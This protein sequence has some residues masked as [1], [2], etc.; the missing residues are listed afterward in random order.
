MDGV[1]IPSSPMET[2]RRGFISLEGA[3]SI[4][5]TS[6]GP[7]EDATPV[8]IEITD[9]LSR[10]RVIDIRMSLEAFADALMGHGFRP[11]SITF[12]DTGTVGMKG[13]NKTE[14]VPFDM[15]GGSRSDEERIKKALAPFEVEGW[16]ARSSDM[17]NGHCSTTKDGKRHQSVVFFRHVPVES[18]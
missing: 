10:T 6:G 18:K 16:R 1:N 9:E 7:N 8:R 5:R 14:L 3:I 4:G 12:N 13:E 15:Y 17:T 2:A 11:C